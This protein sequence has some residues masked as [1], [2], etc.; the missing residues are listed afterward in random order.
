[1]FTAAGQVGW[2]NE[3]GSD[4]YILLNTD[5]D[6]ASDG[7]IRVLGVHSIDASWFVL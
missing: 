5:G 7:V 1:V 4:T 2:F 3:P 6:A